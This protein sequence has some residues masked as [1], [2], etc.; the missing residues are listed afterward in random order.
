MT[1]Q[2]IKGSGLHAASNQELRDLT[3]RAEL[4]DKASRAVRSKGQKFL[5]RH[6]ESAQNQAAQRGI[7]EGLKKAFA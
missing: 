5:S 4:E 6:F 2:K 3:A 1:R 7:Q